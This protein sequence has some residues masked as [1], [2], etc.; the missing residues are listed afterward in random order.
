MQPLDVI[1]LWRLAWNDMLFCFPLPRAEPVVPT[2]V[3]RETISTRSHIG[4]RDQ[5]WHENVI[6]HQ[7]SWKRGTS[8]A[9]SHLISAIL[10]WRYSLARIVGY[11]WH[12]ATL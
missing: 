10:V 12:L 11:P 1:L 6:I 4:M 3:C 7:Q 8:T 9:C 2:A 5:I